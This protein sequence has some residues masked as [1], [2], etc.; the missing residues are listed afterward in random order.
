MISSL[1]FSAGIQNIHG[2]FFYF[3]STLSYAALFGVLHEMPGEFALVVREYHSRLY[4]VPAYFL[5]RV[6]SYWPVYPI[7]GSDSL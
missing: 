1:Y 6:I 5:A 3:I 4:C 7:D 2:V